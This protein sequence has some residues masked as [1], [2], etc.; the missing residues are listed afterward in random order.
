MKKSI[1]VGA[2]TA[3]LAFASLA[4]SAEE[5]AKATQV[6]VNFI[7]AGSVTCEKINS[8]VKANEKASALTYGGWANGYLS[9]LNQVGA[10]AKGP[11]VLMNAGGVWNAVKNYC[12][13]NPKEYLATVAAKLRVT[14]LQSQAAA[15]Q[16]KAETK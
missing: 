3:T 8:D 2:L 14:A 15:A 6:R 5:E 4:V 7:G 16:K 1:C 11:Q 9:A 13:N 12:Q 10:A